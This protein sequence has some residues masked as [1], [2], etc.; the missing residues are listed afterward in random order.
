MA[1]PNK[2]GPAIRIKPG[3]GRDIS[4]SRD[5][6][7]VLDRLQDGIPAE[8]RPFAAVAEEL[9]LSEK[10]LLTRLRHWSEAGLLTRFGPLFDA[11]RL[12]GAVCLCAMSVP[13][14][15]FDAVA[16][17]VNA[18]REVA[19]NYARDHALNMWFVV[20]SDDPLRI[21]AAVQ[22][23][24]AEC[25]LDVLRFPKLNEFYIGLKVTPPEETG[26]VSRPLPPATRC[27]DVPFTEEDR[28]LVEAMQA[29]IALVPRPFVRVAEDLDTSEGAVIERTRGMIA[30]GAIRR[31]AAVPNH[32]AL[33]WSE[34]AMTVWDIADDALEDVGRKIGTLPFVSHCYE[35]P[36]HLPDWPYNLFAMVHGRSKAEIETK[37]SALREACGPHLRS[38]NQLVS[39]R[40]LKKTGL[41]L[42]PSNTVAPSQGGKACSA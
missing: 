39:T 28:K 18:H 40:I 12:G 6:W 20:A 14:P 27:E 11:E 34:N 16:D 26:L 33:G 32:Y 22:A 24:E 30:R 13:E 21:E 31:I 19:H 29:G 36:R 41:R 7:R 4:L 25:G 38:A 10:G 1:H 15:R 17:V 9:G 3:K 2:A 35:R 8:S 5:D 23:I 37:I 42:Q